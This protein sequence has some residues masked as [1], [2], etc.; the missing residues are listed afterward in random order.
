MVSMCYRQFGGSGMAHPAGESGEDPVQLRFDRRL[1]L[2]FQGGNI[3]SD[4]ELDEALGLT[5]RAGAAL[6]DL[7]RGRNRRS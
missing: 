1:K 4:R 7:R 5:A 6:S 3:T 2:E